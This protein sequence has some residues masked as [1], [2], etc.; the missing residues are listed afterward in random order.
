MICNIAKPREEQNMIA[1][2]F[3]RGA[4]YIHLI[5]KY[6]DSYNIKKIEK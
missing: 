2:F 4:A 3:I 5:N 6:I 1:Y